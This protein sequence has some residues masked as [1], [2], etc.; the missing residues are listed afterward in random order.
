MLY[1]AI[2]YHTKSEQDLP[3]TPTVSDSPR[4]HLPTV[5]PNIKTPPTHTRIPPLP[6]HSIIVTTPPAGKEP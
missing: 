5:I 6:R 3:K 1:R 4:R 2:Q